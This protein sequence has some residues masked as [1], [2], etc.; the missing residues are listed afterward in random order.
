MNTPVYRRDSCRLCD[1]ISVELVVPLEP[2][3]LSETYS[4]DNETGK[5][6][7]RFPIDLYMC[8]N[9]GHVQQLDHVN[10]EGLWSNYTYAFGNTKDMPRHL[11]EWAMNV[12]EYS[13]PP[14]NSLVID[15]GCNDATMLQTFKRQGYRV[16]GIDP[17][18]A[19]VAKAQREGVPAIQAV[20]S[21]Q[22]AQQIKIQHGTAHIVCS[23]HGFAHID[24]LGEML[25]GIR[26]MLAPN[27]VFV[28]EV[29][30]LLDILE[31]VLIATII[32][33]HMSHHS[34]ASLVNFLGLHG[35][36]LVEVKRSATQHG[37]LIGTAQI[38]GGRLS[39]GDTVMSMLNLEKTRGLGELTTMKGFGKKLVNL[40]QR[41]AK[42]ITKWKLEG[43]KVAG[44]G[45]A[46]SGPTLISQM[47]LTGVIDVI[48]DNH[49]QKVGKFSPGDGILIVQ[50]SEL[51]KRM[52]DY[53]V[54]LAWVHAEQIIANNQKYLEA[55]GRFVVLCPEMRV[56]GRDGELPI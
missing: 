50:T 34:V 7:P 40:Q 56:I 8:V 21:M 41:T 49:S 42:L 3:P 11:N 9:C 10:P 39:I 6:A 28:F 47:G 27:G 17:A 43:A 2:I 23:S 15:V 13:E 25:D 14:E 46:R 36:E 26:A 18:K 31:G 55:G 45:A 24:N 53:T 37:S 20:F 16:L 51:Q 38:T 1:S 48:F 33:E 22:L 4:D 5:N 29:Q 35:L 12:I 54:I 30:Y 52:P 19:M 44:Y 32:H